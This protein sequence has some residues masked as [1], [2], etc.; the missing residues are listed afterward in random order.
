MLLYYFI[1]VIELKV[2][3]ALYALG[4]K[5]CHFVLVKAYGAV[6]PELIVCDKVSAHLAHICHTFTSFVLAVVEFLIVFELIHNLF[7]GIRHGIKLV[8]LI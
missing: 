2:T 8:Y 3:A 7:L 6:I 4:Q 5:T 1:F